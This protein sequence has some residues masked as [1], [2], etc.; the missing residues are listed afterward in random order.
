MNTGTP[1]IQDTLNVRTPQLFKPLTPQ[2]LSPNVLQGKR[3][4]N[5]ILGF[6]GKLKCRVLCLCKSVVH[7]VALSPA[8]EGYKLAN[9]V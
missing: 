5:M 2:L 8:V 6:L 7:G 3:E 1:L 9:E 4:L